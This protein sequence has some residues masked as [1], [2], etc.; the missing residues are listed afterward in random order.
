MASLSLATDLA[1]W[2]SHFQVKNNAVDNLLKILQKHDHT[3]LSSSARSLLKTRQIPTLQKCGMEYL[4][5][6]LRQ[7]LLNNLE[8]YPAEEILDHDTINLSFRIDGL[9]FFKSSVK[10]MWPVLCAI[11]LKPIIVF[12]ATLTCRN[13]KP[14]NLTFLDDVIADLKDLMSSG[15][16][17]RERNFTINVLCIVCDALAKAFIIQGTKLCSGYYGCDKCDQKGQWFSKVTY[18]ATENMTLRTDA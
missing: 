10:V 3:H 11:H 4:H 17:Y 5:Y 1:S 18:P 9:P 16:Q 15:L 8:K 13:K 6:P 12:P 7:Q 14:T 2:A